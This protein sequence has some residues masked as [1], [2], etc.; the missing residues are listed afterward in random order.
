MKQIKQKQKYQKRWFN[1][2]TGRRTNLAEIVGSKSPGK[3]A[4]KKLKG[5]ILLHG[6]AH[7]GAR[8]LQGR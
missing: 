5:V 4:N 6:K 2:T 7:G 3:T 1:T 8:G